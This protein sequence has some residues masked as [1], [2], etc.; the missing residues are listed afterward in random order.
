MG[1][2]HR[3]NKSDMCFYLLVVYCCTTNYLKFQ[4]CKTT[5]IHDLSVSM[6][7]E[8]WQSLAESSISGYLTKLK[9]RYCPK[10]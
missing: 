2:T 5:H 4:K 3:K 9:S 10:W 1:K 7:Q 8:S 6:D